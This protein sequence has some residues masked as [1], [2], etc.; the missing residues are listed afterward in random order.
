MIDVVKVKNRNEGQ[1]K[2]HDLLKRLVDDKTLLALSGGTSPDYKRMIV[3]PGDIRPGAICVVD[4]RFGKPFHKDSTEFLL[5]ESGVKDCADDYCMEAHKILKGED[6]ITTGKIYAEE[7]EEL[8]G[9]FSKRVGL[10][11]VGTNLHTGGI[12]PYSLAAKSPELAVGE[13][14]DDKYKKRVSITLKALGQF[15][16]F[17]ILMFGKEKKDAIK[18][19]LDEAENDMQKYPAIFYRKSKIKSYLITDQ[20]V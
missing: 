8:F 2:A 9:R 6:L 13:T 11:G 14:V 19:M 17:I 10:M 3:K 5:K 7:I 20:N 18:T 12:F 4:D 15:T 1:D 16:G